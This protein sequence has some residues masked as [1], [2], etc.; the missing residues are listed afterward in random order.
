VGR[1]SQQLTA[2]LV[3]RYGDPVSVFAG[4]GS[5]PLVVPGVGALV[6][7]ALLARMRLSIVCRLGAAVC[8]ALVTLTLLSAA[9]VPT[10]V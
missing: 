10:P 9:G 3:V 1:L 5:G 2:G 6:G 7:R 8:A 4:V